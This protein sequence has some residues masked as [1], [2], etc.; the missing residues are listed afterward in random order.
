M[1]FF[2]AEYVKFMNNSVCINNSGASKIGYILA[3]GIFNI[4][5]NKKSD[6]RFSFDLVCIMI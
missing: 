3:S 5:W 1:V 4:Q 2:N 6:N